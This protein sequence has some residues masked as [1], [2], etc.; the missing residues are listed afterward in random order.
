M[1]G[2]AAVAFHA[3]VAFVRSCCCCPTCLLAHGPHQRTQLDHILQ[4]GLE[5]GLAQLLHGL[6]ARG[7]N[8]GW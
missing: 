5:R 4:E 6:Q 2:F 7:I 1:H 3:A 8:S